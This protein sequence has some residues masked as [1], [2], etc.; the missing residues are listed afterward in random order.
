[1]DS[2]FKISIIFGNGTDQAKTYISTLLAYINYLNCLTSFKET[3]E[4]KSGS[5]LENRFRNVCLFKPAETYGPNDPRDT[6]NYKSFSR[7]FSVGEKTDPGFRLEV[8]DP[9]FAIDMPISPHLALERK[10]NGDAEKSFLGK[11]TKDFFLD[12]SLERISAF[13]KSNTHIIIETAGGILVELVRG[14]SNIKFTSQILNLIKKKYPGVAS[15]IILCGSGGLGC[16]NSSLLSF[17]KLCHENLKPNHLILSQVS[18]DMDTSFVLSNLKEIK[19]RIKEKCRY[20]FCPY[21][22]FQKNEKKN[23]LEL[24]AEIN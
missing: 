19:M 18:E 12:E 17:E 8:P 22:I 21:N 5:L 20:Y 1:L 6:E 4:K 11:I 9:V 23:L 3:V 16:I 2:G 15:E 14:L 13:F 24:I 10:R 7:L